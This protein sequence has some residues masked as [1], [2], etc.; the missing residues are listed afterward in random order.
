M[1][2]DNIQSDGNE[3]LQ[4]PCYNRQRYLTFS[5]CTT[6]KSV[7]PDAPA[8]STAAVSLDLAAC[9]ICND[10]AIMTLSFG[11]TTF[12][13]QVLQTCTGSPGSFDCIS[14]IVAFVGG[15]RQHF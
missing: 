2:L 8:M 11:G 14:G 6:M 9:S 15:P 1:D 5:C 12:A 3:I 13:S 4:P 10:F 7:V